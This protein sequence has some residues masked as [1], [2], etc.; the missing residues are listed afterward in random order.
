MK[1]QI[2]EEGITKQ[3]NEESDSLNY[4]KAL[5]LTADEPLYRQ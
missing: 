3:S 5:F 1:N 4:K 2:N